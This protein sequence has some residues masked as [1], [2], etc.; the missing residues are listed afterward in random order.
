MTRRVELNSKN[1]ELTYDQ[2]TSAGKL[3]KEG[4]GYKLVPIPEI[5]I[6]FLF[7]EFILAIL[8]D[9]TIPDGRKWIYAG[10][11]TQSI[12][13]GITLGGKIDSNVNSRRKIYLGPRINLIF[14]PKITA[15]YSVNVKLP[16]WFQDARIM[17][18]RYTGIDEDFVQ[19]QLG[20]LKTEIGSI[21]SEITDIQDVLWG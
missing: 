10:L 12:A 4:G 3:P 6:P 16:D 5:A 2:S 11:A 19:S 8:I 13:S 7:N 21:K 14:F 1:W 18:W 20:E 17:V 9:T 15:N